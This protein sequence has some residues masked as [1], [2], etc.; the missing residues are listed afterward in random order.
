VVIKSDKNKCSCQKAVNT[1][2]ILTKLNVLKSKYKLTKTTLKH[3]VLKMR[4]VRLYKCNNITKLKKRMQH[5]KEC[6]AAETPKKL[7]NSFST[8]PLLYWFDVVALFPFLPD[9]IY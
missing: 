2:L 5:L 6:D 4:R 7:K 3:F 8:E 9:Q 1:P